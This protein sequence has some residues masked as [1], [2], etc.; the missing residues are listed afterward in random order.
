MNRPVRHSTYVPV[1]KIFISTVSADPIYN[2][3]TG[4]HERWKLLEPLLVLSACALTAVNAAE[5]FDRG[6]Y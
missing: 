3:R 4:T 6:L 1:A 5:F 2:Q